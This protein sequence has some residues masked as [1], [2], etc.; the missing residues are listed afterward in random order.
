[1]TGPVFVVMST[2]F[3]LLGTSYSLAGAKRIA[4]DAFPQRKLLWRPAPKGYRGAEVTVDGDKGLAYIW[5]S[6]PQ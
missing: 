4:E 1:M 3:E 2:S 6:H 5:P